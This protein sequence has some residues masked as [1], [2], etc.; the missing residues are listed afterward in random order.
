MIMGICLQFVGIEHLESGVS[1]HLG[2]TER[3]P[4]WVLN[5]ARKRGRGNPLAGFV[6]CRD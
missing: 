5:Q 6:L 1:Y 2:S 3:S 4:V